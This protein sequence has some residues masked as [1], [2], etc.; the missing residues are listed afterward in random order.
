MGV[1]AAEDTQ[2]KSSRSTKK[3]SEISLLSRYAYIFNSAD[4]S[5]TK[6][7]C[8]EGLASN[9]YYNQSFNLNNAQLWCSANES[10]GHY[11]L[12]QLRFLMEREWRDLELSV[13]DS[14]AGSMLSRV[15]VVPKFK[16]DLTHYSECHNFIG[17]KGPQG[18]ISKKKILHSRIIAQTIRSYT[19]F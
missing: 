11:T 6:I 8:H 16:G 3:L 18:P 2:R 1:K 14:I 9:I 4:I 10:R 7:V 13:V 19:P 17:L 12:E 15:S 5:A